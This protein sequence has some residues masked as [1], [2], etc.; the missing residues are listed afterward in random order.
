MNKIYGKDTSLTL[1]K[2]NEYT[3][4]CYTEETLRQTVTDFELAATIGKTQRETRQRTGT[5]IEGCLVTRLDADSTTPLFETVC[6]DG[7]IFTLL[8]DRVFSKN[9][10]KHL[11]AQGF[12]I[13]AAN[14][15]PFYFRIDVKE[16]RDS[17]VER[18]SHLT[19]VINW[20]SKQLREADLMVEKEYSSVGRIGQKETFFYD[21]FSVIKTVQ[22]KETR[23]PLIHRFELAGDFSENRKFTLSLCYAL[24]ERFYPELEGIEKIIIPISEKNGMYLEMESVKPTDD[25]SHIRTSNEILISQKFRVRGHIRFVARNRNGFVRIE[26]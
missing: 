20:S 19:P 11:K 14:K 17:A 9:I 7:D 5:R 26:I 24:N 25:A 12:V 23:L 6:D 1:L 4:L 18:F 10:F 13:R 15:E 16:T 21:G 2:D 22:R 3:P 8:A